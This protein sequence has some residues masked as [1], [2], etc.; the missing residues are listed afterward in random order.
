MPDE[1]QPIKLFCRGCGQKLDVS[2]LEPFSKAPCPVC[3]TM[4]R[5]PKRFGRYLLEKICGIGGMSKVYRAIDPENVRR[6]AVKILDPEFYDE[7]RGGDQ[8]IYESRLLAGISHPGLIPVIDCGV[9]DNQPFLVMPYMER[10]S[11]EAMVKN[12]KLP[13]L[14]ILY[15]WLATVSD[16]LNTA[17]SH[18][19]LHHDIKP[20][21]I[22]VD[23]D[24]NAAL[25]DFDL[26]DV[27]SNIESRLAA[28]GWA[29]PAYVSPERLQTGH[30]DWQG[31]VFSL[32]AS[33]YELLTGALPFSTEGETEELIERRR[34][35]I[36]PV[37]SALNERISMPVSNIIMQML[38]FEPGNRPEYKDIIA[39]F[40]QEAQNTASGI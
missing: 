35:L 40:T 32:G 23:M 31:D 3:G 20:G 4:L 5:V 14:P 11:L 37:P 1:T 9:Q 29:S 7:Y 15:S 36:P 38:S 33:A 26:A 13:D 34:T 24:C 39:V 28:S 18:N 17:L 6:V 12:K 30:E 25:G 2:E 10:G 21:N 22:L 27:R 8:F 19:M 16:G